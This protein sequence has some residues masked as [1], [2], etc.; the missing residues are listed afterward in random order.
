MLNE[1]RDAYAMALNL[2]MQLAGTKD[3]LTRM[4]IIGLL[5]ENIIKLNPNK[6]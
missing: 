1:K 2:L 6:K 4:A 3:E 5:L